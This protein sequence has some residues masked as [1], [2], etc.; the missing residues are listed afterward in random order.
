MGFSLY[1]YN[2]TLTKEEKKTLIQKELVCI[3]DTRLVFAKKRL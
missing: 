1:K 2:L 3:K